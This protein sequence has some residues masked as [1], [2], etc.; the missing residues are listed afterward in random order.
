MQE[1]YGRDPKLVKKKVLAS[2]GRPHFPTSVWSDVISNTYVDLNKLFDF[3]FATDGPSKRSVQH[4]G[5]FDIVTNECAWDR[6]QEAVVFLYPHRAREVTTYAK[7]IV[8]TFIAVGSNTIN[9]S[10]PVSPKV[11]DFSSPTPRPSTQ[12]TPNLSTA[13]RREKKQSDHD[14]RKNN[15]VF[16]EFEWYSNV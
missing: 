9:A 4:V 8:E 6:Y 1:N 3:H 13:P 10:A 12:T 2:Q 7:H 14:K 16:T 5:Q 15:R 11:S